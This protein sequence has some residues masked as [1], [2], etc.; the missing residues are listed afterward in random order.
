MQKKSS[1]SVKIRYPL[2]EKEVNEKVEIFSKKL[3]QKYSVKLVI[4]FGSYARNSYSFGSDVDIFVVHNDP[5]LSFE[6]ALTI[7]LS[8]SIE[9]DWQIHIYSLKD[10][11]KAMNESNPF[12]QTIHKTGKVIFYD[13]ND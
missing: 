7:A 13:L 3:R 8:V 1:N 4:L 6:Q 2:S 11:Q 5:K 12:F 10:Y 9:I